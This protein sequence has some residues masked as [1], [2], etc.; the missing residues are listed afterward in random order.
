VEKNVAVTPLFW[1]DG[2]ATDVV[3]ISDRGFQYGDGLFETMR[4]ADGDIPL[5][6][7]HWQRLTR[8][9]Q[10]LYLPFSEDDTRRQL[11]R[12]IE[13]CRAEQRHDGVI[14]LTITRGSGGRGYSSIGCTGRLVL[15]WFPA[16]S[17]LDR[18]RADGVEVMFCQTQLGHSQ[19]LA[20]LKHLNR[21]EQVLARREV[22]ASTCGE[23][24]LQ[25]RDG[26]VIEGTVSNL[27][28]VESGAVVTPNL[29]FCGVDGVFRQWLLQDCSTVD[30]VGINNITRERLLLADEVFLGNSVMG[31]I[32]VSC[33]EGRVWEPGPVTRR[34]QQEILRIFHVNN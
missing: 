4:M 24:L 23:G 15:S 28:L 30:V 2:I 14:K 33:C 19:T 20:G 8:S 1:V 12:F 3:P 17:L 10:R 22:D 7:R 21:L 25:D 27:F 5:L 9:C 31:V 26:W 11:H 18:N 32:P 29:D 16:P 34:V 6:H 13:F